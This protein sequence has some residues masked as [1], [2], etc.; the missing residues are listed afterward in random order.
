MQHTNVKTGS[1]QGSFTNCQCQIRVLLLRNKSWQILTRLVQNLKLR[2]NCN[3][4]PSLPETQGVVLSKQSL[5]IHI[6]RLQ[7]VT[8]ERWN[9]ACCTAFRVSSGWFPH[10]RFE[11]SNLCSEGDC[12]SQY[13]LNASLSWQMFRELPPFCPLGSY[14]DGN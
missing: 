6:T 7:F 14:T 13:T 9:G 10:N 8:W 3:L 5:D 12:A 4:I 2:N 11:H 1:K